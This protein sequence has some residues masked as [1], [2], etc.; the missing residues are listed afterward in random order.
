MVVVDQGGQIVLVNREAEHQFGYGRNLLIGLQVEQIIPA[1]FAERILADGLRS[2]E[3]ARAQQ[4]GTGIELTGLRKDG[5][6]FPIEIMLSPLESAEGI[7]LVTAA[8]RNISARKAADAQL[9]RM[10][11]RYRGL[12]EAAPDP[13]IVLNEAGKIVFLNLQTRKQFGY[14]S[15]ELTDESVNTIIPEGLAE[16]L[17]PGRHGGP[18]GALTQQMGPAIELTG[19]RKNGDRFPIELML[20]PLESAEGVLVTVAI[21]DIS[22]RREA[23]TQRLE[24]IEELNRSN[25]ELRQFAH[26][27]SHDLQEPLRMVSSFTQLLARKYKGQLDAQADEFITYAVDGANRMQQLIQD[28]LAFSRVGTNGR[29]LLATPSGQALGRAL[30]NLRAALEESGATVTHDVLPVVLADETQLVQLFQNLVGN[31]VKYH[32]RDAPVVHV[33]A[34]REGTNGWR[35]AV[36]DNGLGIEAHY[37]DR[38][39]GL[40]QRLHTRDEFSGTGI[41]LA[42]CKK[43]VER[44]GGTIAVAS[45][46][47][48]GST[49]TFTLEGSHGRSTMI[50]GGGRPVQVLL[51]EDS[52]GD[53]R[54]TREALSSASRPVVLHVAADGLEAMAFLRRE[55]VHVD[56]PRPD[57]ILLDLNLPRMDGREVLARIKADAGLKTIPTVILTTSSSEDDIARS[58]ELHA[59]CYLR[60]PVQLD[61]FD[62]L[63]TSINDFWL[64]KVRLPAAPQR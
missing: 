38:I 59:N 28:L 62:K 56:A 48:Q 20:S 12:L 25:E 32:G 35:F 36:E 10:E 58:Y 22:S 23:E 50:G 15:D 54:L 2:V 46:P 40:F 21:R 5:S 60:K 19:R 57:L 44:H 17:Q 4:I 33:S 29:G 1:G 41:G 34:R 6:E 24:R 43:I 8:I 37:F 16:L 27:A 11:A 52:P 30:V 26:V 42:I 39:F 3:E 18:P 45:V 55:S 51:V 64:T 47:G 13:M 31:A 53:V 63:V 7:T 9:A 61:A 49:F 14:G